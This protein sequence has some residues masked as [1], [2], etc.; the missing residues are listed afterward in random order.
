MAILPNTLNLNNLTVDPATGRVSFSGLGTGIDWQ[1]AIQGII[2]A[3]QAPI[4]TLNQKI[5]TNEAKIAALEDL[6]SYV[7]TLQNAISTLKGAVTADNSSNIFAAKQTF[8]STARTD[9]LTPS[10]PTS[11]IG[12]S[13]TNVAATGVHTLEVRRV[14][15]AHKI[16]SGTFADQATALGFSGGFD[17]TGNDTATI[18]VSATDTLQ[19]IRDRIN[20]ANTGTNA[21]G[22]SASIVQI[23][24]T[25]FTLVLTNTTTGQDIVLDNE[26]GG[27]LNSLGISADGG[28]TFSNEL[29]TAQTA[30]FTV[31]GLKDA[32]RFESKF[33]SSSS[34]QLSSI[35][36][37]ATFPGSFD[38]KVGADTVTVNYTGSDTLTDLETNINNAITAAGGGNA[39]FDAGTTASVVADGTGYRLVITNSSGAAI[40]FN[41]TDGLVDGLGLNN[42]LVVERT[43][44][45]VNDVFP[46][47]TLSLFQAEEGTTITLEIEQ[48]QTAVK[49]TVTGLV[50]A[51]NDLRQFI[52]GQS[53]VDPTT[54]QKA[55]SAG[56]LFGSSTLANVK[57]TLA[58]I[59]GAGVGG[60]STEF[61]V[62][63]QIGITFVDNDTVADPSLRDTLEIDEAE[64]DSAILNSPEDIERLFAFDFTTSDP[65][66]TLLSFTGKTAYSGTGYT[67]NLTHDGSNLTGADFGGVAS[68][69]TVNGNI[70]TATSATGAEGLKLLYT[71]TGDASGIQID[72]TVG[73]A[74][75]LSFAL[76]NF[77]DTTNGTIE[78]DIEGLKDQNTQNSA[79]VDSLTALLASQANILTQKFINMETAL[80]QAA[81]LQNTLDQMFAALNPQN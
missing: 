80:A 37:S 65:R 62:L 30:R 69:A 31:D 2:A 78:A 74:A 18:T 16:G 25:E 14:A 55:A 43:T 70:L 71:G 3:R 44:N 33:V 10:P 9:G 59:V 7:T 39:V 49:D 52:N 41:D 34:A 66:I 40:S 38:I 68:S 46:G 15:T 8:A 56:P 47:V 64:L 23:S 61:S 58:Q 63:A 72:F 81:T 1:S 4:D 21:T 35:A 32:D 48:D 17:I 11:L 75:Q 76:D 42:D 50:T 45:T 51:Y 28:T 6:R 26:S 24:A 53:L 19:D 73:M 22:V 20:N 13:V 5:T 77:L 67:L 60:V 57:Q 29:Q 54:G 12:A 27:V 79:R 36:S